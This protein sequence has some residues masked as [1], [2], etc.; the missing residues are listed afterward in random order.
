MSD[1]PTGSRNL[2]LT[3]PLVSSHIYDWRAELRTEARADD[4]SPG[5]DLEVTVDFFDSGQDYGAEVVHVFVEDLNPDSIPPTTTVSLSGTDGENGWYTSSV[6]ASL[7]ATDIG[8]GVENTTY[9]INDGSWA[10]YTSSFTIDI[11]GINTI[12]YYSV[13]QANNKEN[14]N[15]LDIKIDTTQPTGQVTINNDDDYADSQVVTL[16]TTADDGGGS[17]LYQMRFRNEGDI[18]TNSWIDYTTE[19]TP[20]TLKTGD[21]N[22]RVYA[23]FKDNAGNISPTSSDSIT[24]DTEPPTTT[25]SLSGA[26]GEN[27]WYI[28]AVT[29][30]LSASDTRSGVGYTSYRINEE[31][32]SSYTGSFIVD[33]EGINTIDYYSVDQANNKENTNTLDIKID[34]TQPTGQVTINNDD[35]YTSTTLVTLSLTYEDT[36]SG[37]SEVRYSNDGVWDTE[38]WENPTSTKF[39]TLTPGEGIKKVYY[40]FKDNAGNISPTSSDSIILDTEPPSATISINEGDEYTNSTSVTL[41]LQYSDNEGVDQ[42]R[43]SNDGISYTNWEQPSENKSWTLSSED[44]IKTVYAQIRDRAGLNSNFVFDTIIL[45]TIPPTGSIEINNGASSTTSTSVTITPSA[46]D[47]NGVNQM[48]LRNE[49]GDWSNW[50]EV[51]TKTWTLASGLGLKTV[52]AQFKDNTGLVS[53]DF[54]A[55]INLVESE[56]SP[57]PTPGAT[58]S[59]K[60]NVIIY[61]KYENNDPAFG[62]TVTTLTIPTGQTSLKGI[63][64]S[65]GVV[66][67]NNIIIG[68]YSFYASKGIYGSNNVQ[69]IV[70]SQQTTSVNI[71]LVE[72]LIEP[73]ISVD[74]MTENSGIPRKIFSVTAEDDIQGSGISTVTL[75]I[76]E[77]PVK[78]WTTAGTHVYDEG[79]YSK[80]KHTFYVEAV[81]NAGNRV[82]NPVSGY[83]EFAVEESAL[84]DQMELWKL[85]G[86]ILVAVGG[87][88]LVMLSIRIKK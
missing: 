70:N 35:D 21:G 27:D 61:V 84:I 46:T 72:D 1:E 30:T 38:A 86:I 15:T 48:R 87:I 45:D 54:F 7:S 59:E 12:D 36:A 51:T 20:W 77:S 24:L 13:D 33:I 32:W 41:Y 50:E 29:I 78:T 83:L 16:H 60:G 23:Q 76:D 81:D 79:I 74:L 18:W 17:G 22:K 63:T 25:E 64:D 10:L 2:V 5:D 6:T 53:S 8:Y 85:V 40:Q 4:D 69:V 11:E 68:S 31:P 3:T 56:P 37:V 62:V 43:Y 28:G 80:G 88:T 66:T 42:V 75:Y 49:E 57:T 26:M 55:T 71:T 52:F 34:T 82:R 9:R 19:P 58:P 39:W 65:N 44:G 47:A 14:T 73:V 67:F